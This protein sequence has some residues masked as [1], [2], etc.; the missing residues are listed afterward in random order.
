MKKYSILGVTSFLFLTA[1]CSSGS[2]GTTDAE[3]AEAFPESGETI[4]FIVPYSAG[5][6]A[7]TQARITAQLLEGVLDATVQVV[8]RE[9]G[10][11]VIGLTEL[12]QADP[13]GYTVGMISMPNALAWVWPKVQAPYDAD[14]FEFISSIS[15]ITDVVAVRA[16]SP[17]ETLEDLIEAATED[18]GTIIAS[19]EGAQSTDMLAIRNL[20]EATGMKLKTAIYADGASEKVAALL[21]GQVDVATLAA[22]TALPQVESGEFRVLASL[23]EEP[24]DMYEGAP[25]A[26]S[27]GYDVVSQTNYTLALPAGTPDSVRGALED[28]MLEVAQTSEFEEKIS[29]LGLIPNVRN[30]DD[31]AAMAEQVAKKTTKALALLE[32]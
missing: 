24:L 18:P 8:N 26:A 22:A 23:S 3:A 10:N 2:D 17:Y 15:D 29:A 4:S 13:D 25:T 31:T 9:G 11:T 21:G 5:G 14:D 1:A 32:S 6:P 20:E 7:D 27:L 28:A 19:V 16:D 30:S 12:A